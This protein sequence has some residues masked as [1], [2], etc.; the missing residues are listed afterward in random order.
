MDIPIKITDIDSDADKNFPLNETKLIQDVNEKILVVNKERQV[1]IKP[2]SI[3]NIQTEDFKSL[4]NNVRGNS[5]METGRL[6]KIE[7]TP[8][9]PDIK[10]PPIRSIA[11]APQKPIERPIEGTST[12]E[13]S[14]ILK[15]IYTNVLNRYSLINSKLNNIY[16]DP[17]TNSAEDKDKLFINL[18]VEMEEEGIRIV[19]YKDKDGKTIEQITFE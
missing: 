10:N 19:S 17:N 7:T 9:T 3:K 14:E 4:L 1:N 13:E 11:A 15:E 2:I 12:E 18:H 16:I 6:S 8:Q 5:R